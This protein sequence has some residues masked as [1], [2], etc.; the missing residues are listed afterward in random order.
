[1]TRSVT[2]PLHDPSLWPMRMTRQ[3]TATVLRISERELRRRIAQHRFPVPDDGRTWSRE[4][5]ERYAKGT[6][7]EFERQY[8]RTR[9][10][11]QRNVVRVTDRRKQAL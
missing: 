10:A 11:Q 6:I 3:D 9:E 2:I 4:M 1:M 8:E 7:R 5:V